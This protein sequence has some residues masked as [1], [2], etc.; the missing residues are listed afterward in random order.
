M[1]EV[2]NLRKTFREAKKNPFA[3][4]SADEM[5]RKGAVNAVDGISFIAKP[6]QVFGLIGDNGAGKTTTLRIL[7]TVIAPTGG[8]AN[9]AGFD[10]V[11]D[12]AKVRASIGFISGTTNG[13]P[14]S[15]RKALELSTIK[16]PAFT[17]ASR[18]AREIE[19]PALN[20]ASWQPLKESFVNSR[21]VYVLP[22]NSMV[23]PALRLD[24]SSTNSVTGN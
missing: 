1:V 23:V 16:Q 13:T 6:G 14:S 22:L 8:T 4:R 10:V 18:N 21:T 19:A 3:K 15:M 9:I 17:Q 2:V 5:E 20:S 24:A 12:P 11:D 7:S